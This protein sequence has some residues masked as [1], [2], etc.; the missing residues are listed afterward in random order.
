MID[1]IDFLSFRR[2]TPDL[3]RFPKCDTSY[4]VDICVG[5][6]CDICMLWFRMLFKNALP[7][8]PA[9]LGCEPRADC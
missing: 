4:E 9:E 2:L 1:S 7:E 3:A 8:D 5:G 6:V